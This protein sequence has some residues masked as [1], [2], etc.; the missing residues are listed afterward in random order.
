MVIMLYIKSKLQAFLLL[1]EHGDLSLMNMCRT[2]MDYWHM[3][4]LRFGCHSVS[5]S[6]V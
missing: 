3:L 4:R 5:G 1:S 2:H 6:A